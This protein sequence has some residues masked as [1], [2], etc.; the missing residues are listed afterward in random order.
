MDVLIQAYPHVSEEFLE[1][2][3]VIAD[4][5]VIDALELLRLYIGTPGDPDKRGMIELS[6]DD[7]SWND[8]DLYGPQPEPHE[9]KHETVQAENSKDDV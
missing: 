4:L 9:Q 1:S 5:D 7:I 8:S 3:L 6:D 2:T